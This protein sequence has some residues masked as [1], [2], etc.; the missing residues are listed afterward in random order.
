MLKQRVFKVACLAALTLLCACNQTR[1]TTIAGQTMGTTYSIKVRTEKSV[2]RQALQ[3]LI[4]ERLDQINDIM[5]TYRP[6]SELSK[7]NQSESRE[8]L[9]VSNDLAKVLR[10][11][12]EIGALTQGAFDITINPVVELWGFGPTNQQD[13]TLPAD[14]DIK[15]AMQ[16]VGLKKLLLNYDAR[17]VRKVDIGVTIDLSGVAKGYAVDEIARLLH[18]QQ[19]KHFMVEVGGEIYTRGSRA[20]NKRWRIAIEKPHVD[21]RS[22]QRVVELTDLAMASSGNYRNFY[23]GPTGRMYSH[24]IDPRDGKPVSH[25]LAAVTVVEKSCMRADALATAL[26]VLGPQ[27]G[28]DLAEEND[29]AALFIEEGGD[30]FVEKPTK[31]FERMIRQ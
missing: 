11:A 6:D 18:D 2:D 21:R 1:I 12:L 13:K 27:R 15:R 31:A 9:K 8:W 24:T 5:S 10:S 14:A 16:S 26:L 25:N 7:L 30:G 4:D 23:I 22:V 20:K 3:A 17:L 29:M 28:F 19:I